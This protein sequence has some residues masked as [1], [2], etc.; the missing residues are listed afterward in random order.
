MRRFLIVDIHIMDAVMAGEGRKSGILPPSM[1]G[2]RN[3]CNMSNFCGRNRK[4][5]LENRQF[6]N[7]D[8]G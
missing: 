8:D 6:L 7:N 1:S 2:E 4:D 3:G 5:I